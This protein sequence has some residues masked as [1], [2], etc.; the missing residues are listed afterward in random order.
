MCGIGNC[1]LHVFGL[2]LEKL[3]LEIVDVSCR[4][5]RSEMNGDVDVLEAVNALCRRV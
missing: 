5:D 3:T 4:I 2:H 1:H